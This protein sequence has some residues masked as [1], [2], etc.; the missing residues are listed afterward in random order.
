VV[1]RHGLGRGQR[2]SWNGPTVGGVAQTVDETAW[3]D[4][5]GRL[6]I[7]TAPRFTSNSAFLCSTYKYDALGR[8]VQLTPPESAGSQGHRVCVQADGGPT[9]PRR[10]TGRAGHE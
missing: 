5:M 2:K 1:E 3:Y 4:P 9:P 8:Q 6:A 7:R 10:Q